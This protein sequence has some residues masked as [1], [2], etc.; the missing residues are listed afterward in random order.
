MYG[1]AKQMLMEGDNLLYHFTT[2]EALFKI[3]KQM[4]IRL[5]TFDNLNDLNEVDMCCKST[6]GGFDLIKLREYIKTKGRLI[7]FSQKRKPTYR[8]TINLPRMWAQYAN[9]CEG[10]CIV[11]NKQAFEA[12]NKNALNGKRYS[13]SKV[14]YKNKLKQCEIK[15]QDNVEDFAWNNKKTLL[16]QKICL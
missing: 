10:V 3:L 14:K 2:A 1:S 7:S 9:N 8:S 15:P 12:E 4:R 16:C 6:D 13:F 11:I 5:S